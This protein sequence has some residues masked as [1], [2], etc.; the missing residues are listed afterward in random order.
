MSA[1]RMLDRVEGNRMAF[2]EIEEFSVR[3]GAATVRAFPNRR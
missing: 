3:Y 1:G 2:A